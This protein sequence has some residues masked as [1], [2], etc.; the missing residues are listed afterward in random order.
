MLYFDYESP[1][2]LRDLLQCHLAATMAEL[3]EQYEPPLFEE[4]PE[5]KAELRQF[6]D[7]YET[8]LR[9]L[10]AEW[11]SERDSGPHNLD[12]GKLILRV[13]RGEVDVFQSQIINGMEDVKQLLQT[14]AREL[15]T[16]DRHDLFADGGVSFYAFW[17]RGTEIIENLETAAQMMESY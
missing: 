5:V 15:R 4:E 6:L 13:A 9:R 10:E 12:E 3:M 16:L 2:Q 14:A 8:F 1:E 17:K 7:H 11:A